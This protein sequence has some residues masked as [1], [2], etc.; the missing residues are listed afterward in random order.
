MM[1]L[2]SVQPG[3]LA[4]LAHTGAVVTLLEVMPSSLV[5]VRLPTRKPG[6]VLPT[7]VRSHELDRVEPIEALYERMGHHA[8]WPPE[9]Y[10]LPA[11]PADDDTDE[12]VRERLADPNPPT[13]VE[14]IL[15]WFAQP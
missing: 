13:D 3:L 1:P 8:A 15:R 9:P 6:E 11:D 10:E 14:R 2:S 12:A 7:L 5:R 4:R